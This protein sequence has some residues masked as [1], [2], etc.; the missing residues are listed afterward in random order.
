MIPRPSRRSSCPRGPAFARLAFASL[1]CAALWLGAAGSARADV[2]YVQQGGV[3]DAIGCTT[4]ECSVETLS[5]ADFSEV[6]GQLVIDTGS[7][8]PTM[9][10]ALTL[11]ND[12]VSLLET[13]AGTEDNGVAE[14]ELADVTYEASALP[15][16]EVAAGSFSIDFGASATLEGDQTQWSDASAAVNGTPAAFS[17]GDVLVTG[18]CLV[19]APGSASCS[20]TFGTGGFELLVG[21]PSPA[22][23]SLSQ[24]MN[25]VLLP[26]PG[27]GILLCAGVAGLAILARVRAATTRAAGTPARRQG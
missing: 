21:D 4:P 5:L 19:V 3:D 27:E 1:A 17:D 2:F 14:L 22:P 24:T 11:W 25:L 6:F 10:F 13:V 16:T 15:L 12:P 18:G 8:P 23:R 9:S 7:I 20:L 26:E